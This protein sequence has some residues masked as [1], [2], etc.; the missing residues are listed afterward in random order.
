MERLWA[1]WRM[2]YI[3]NP[4]KEC[5]LCAALKSKDQEPVFIIEKFELGFTIMNR[6]PYNNGHLLIAPVRH[7]GQIEL[8][9]DEEILTIQRLLSRAIMAMNQAFHP[10]GFNIGINQGRIAGAGLVDHLHYHLVPRWLGDTNFMPIISDTKVISEALNRTYKQIKSA[11]D[12][13]NNL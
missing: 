6:Y 3:R 13:L 11:L 9:N 1:P 4:N 2:E 10:D 5:F 8:L 7:I 12:N